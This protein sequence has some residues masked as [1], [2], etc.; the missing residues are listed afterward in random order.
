MRMFRLFAVIRVLAKIGYYHLT[1]NDLRLGETLYTGFSKLG[2]IYIKFL[3]VM[4]LRADLFDRWQTVDH[5]R[6][7]EDVDTEPLDIRRMLQAELGAQA[8]QLELESEQPFAGGSFGQVYMARLRSGDR[9]IIKALRPSLVRCLSFD[10]R[11]IGFAVR[12]INLLKPDVKI[13]LKMLF[14]EFKQTT[15]G[16]TNYVRE[17][18]FGLTL[19]E[20]YKDHSHLVIPKTFAELTTRKILVQEYVEGISAVELLDLKR[21]G[22]SP[23]E[24]VQAQLGSDL[25]TQMATLGFELIHGVFKH[26]SIQGD[27]HPGNVRLMRDNKV[28]LIDFGISAPSPTDRGVVV[29][30]LRE[31]R[32]C[33]LGD[34]D[35]ESFAVTSLRFY[36]ADL[37]AAINVLDSYVARDQAN[38]ILDELGRAASRRFHSR[39][40]QNDIQRLLQRGMLTTIFDR[41]I[42]E[43]NRFGLRLHH[44]SPNFV[45]A[46]QLFMVLVDSLD[47]KF[48]VMPDVFKA[49]IDQVESDHAVLEGAKRFRDADRAMGV[50]A[51]WLDRVSMKDPALFSKL[52]GHIRGA[53]HA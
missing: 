21:K 34:F 33:Y 53:A 48:T 52:Q 1:Q 20:R 18:G 42:N 49:V 27:P 15:L 29:D 51:A 5:L 44:E 8:G 26:D 2:G 28:G 22:K 19:H 40:S 31:Y 30:M 41:I 37:V 35:I 25:D 38:A 4:L 45:R 10:L 39:D 3:Q 46:G 50:V 6:V 23:A 47:C 43:N 9:V 13:D 36:A 14:K 12:V 32:K 7:Y 16:E 11:L 24:Y 17:A